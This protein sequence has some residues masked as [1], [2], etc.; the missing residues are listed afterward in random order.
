VVGV[1][2]SSRIRSHSCEPTEERVDGHRPSH[3]LPCHW[4][5]FCD[6]ILG[7]STIGG[8]DSIDREHDGEIGMCSGDV[9]F[10][11]QLPDRHHQQPLQSA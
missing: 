6:E 1:T 5:V 2:P 8:G 11:Y 4:L 7:K 3:S 9:A 10:L